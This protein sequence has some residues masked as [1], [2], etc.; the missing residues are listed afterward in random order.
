MTVETFLIDRFLWIDK[1]SRRVNS[2]HLRICH[3]ND[4]AF[5]V[6]Y[7]QHVHV[8]N[9]LLRSKRRNKCLEILI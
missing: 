3:N 7:V 4:L 2:E 9:Q 5:T 6:I 1:G 8:N